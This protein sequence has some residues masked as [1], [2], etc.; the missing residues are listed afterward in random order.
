MFWLQELYLAGKEKH[1]LRV[2][3]LKNIFQANGVWEQAA[4]TILIF[5]RVDFELKLVSLN[6]TKEFTSFHKGE[7]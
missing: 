2:K 5:D 7:I 4:V 1:R 3:G 6:Q